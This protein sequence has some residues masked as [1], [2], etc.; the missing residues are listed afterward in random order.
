M[1]VLPKRRLS[2]KRHV[3]AGLSCVNPGPITVGPRCNSVSK[4]NGLRQSPDSR[5]AADK[6]CS[7]EHGTAMAVETSREHFRREAGRVSVAAFHRDHISRQ[8]QFHW[9]GVRDQASVTVGS[10]PPTPRWVSSGF[11]GQPIG[12]STPPATRKFHRPRVLFS[13]PTPGRSCSIN[14]LRRDSSPASRT[15]PF[16]AALLARHGRHGRRL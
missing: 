13:R 16:T 12:V 9:L 5:N 7:P 3:P 8:P 2:V 14:T 4:A 10:A 1:N 15:F 6:C 11:A